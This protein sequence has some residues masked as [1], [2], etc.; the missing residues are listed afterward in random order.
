VSFNQETALHGRIRVTNAGGTVTG[1]DLTFS[2]G[3]FELS[4]SLRRG[5]LVTSLTDSAVW[6][7]FDDDGALDLA[8][9]GADWD[10]SEGFCYMLYNP[11]T[12]SIADPWIT[13]VHSNAAALM[14]F[15]TTGDF[16]NDNIPDTFSSGEKNSFMSLIGP[17]PFV[18][19][20]AKFRN[21][22]S[23]MTFGNPDG[24]GV[25][26]MFSA[27]G[28]VRDFDHDGKQDVL[29]SGEQYFRATNTGELFTRLYRNTLSGPKILGVQPLTTMQP[30]TVTIPPMGFH[31]GGFYSAN[32]FSLSAG[33]LDGDGFADVYAYSAYSNPGYPAPKWGIYRNNHELDFTPTQ[34]GDP[35]PN[36]YGLSAYGV[37]S[38]VWA[39][40]NG[41]GHD[42]LLLAE[43]GSDGG[44]FTYRTRLL[45]NDGAGNLVE[46]GIVLPQWRGC[47][48]AAG[49]VFNHGRNDIVLSGNGQDN[50]NRTV[51]LRNEGDGTF[52]QMDFGF[53][54]VISGTGVGT[55]LADYD[56]DGRLDFAV[57]GGLGLPA[58]HNP[59]STSLYRNKLAIATNQPPA[60]PV[61]LS[62][63]IAPGTV[64]FA[65]GNATD[66][67][68]PAN[69]L[70]YNLRVGTTPGGTDK[71][72]PLANVT[73]GWR[74]ISAPGNVGHCSGTL[75]RFPPGTYY[76][77]AQAVDGAFAGG[78][79]AAEQTFTITDPEV[80]VL[81]IESAPPSNVRLHWPIRFPEWTLETSTTL[82]PGTWAP[83]T[84]AE[85]YLGGYDLVHPQTAPKEFYRLRKP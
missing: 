81:L 32:P 80:P 13:R 63:A 42:D 66:D 77:S 43:N 2:S 49:D 72:S 16:D 78:A 39:D 14:A 36:F 6:L 5:N 50:I 82:Q 79:W 37:S 7:D 58:D 45:L 57:I 25:D 44:T 51:V 48:A 33:D 70:T 84:G 22:R 31:S 18:Y 34:T 3:G 76:W 29:L 4:L 68:T 19:F 53:Y 11:G 60:A 54:G 47:S 75:Y 1:P 46:S 41:D 65:W 67:I 55:V 56:K 15:I 27:H 40:F 73:T 35:V 69:L 38:P 24:T 12:T 10:N 8:I 9:I 20:G 52:T 59:D 61:A 64:T 85:Y 62:A 17:R 26:E 28:L 30:G 23:A 21:P 83:L 74:K 71:V